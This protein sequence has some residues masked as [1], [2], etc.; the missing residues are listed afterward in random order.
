MSRTAPRALFDLMMHM[1][2][3]LSAAHYAA[4]RIAFTIGAGTPDHHMVQ[5]LTT[6][7][8]F[9]E[10][11]TLEQLAVAMETAQNEDMAQR[12]RAYA[13]SVPVSDV[14]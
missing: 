5:T 6:K 11:R 12:I 9:T 3:H 13:A 14:N 2:R 7:G 1:Q 8:V 4:V 10:A